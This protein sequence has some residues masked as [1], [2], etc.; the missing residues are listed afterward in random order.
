[1]TLWNRC[2]NTNATTLIVR[3]TYHQS[4]ERHPPGHA[5]I[6]FSCVEKAFVRRPHGGPST[7][8]GLPNS[9]TAA[10]SILFQVELPLIR[11]KRGAKK[12]D[13]RE[14]QT[15]Q[16][17]WSHYSRVFIARNQNLKYYLQHIKQVYVC[18]SL[19]NTQQKWTEY[20][21]PCQKNASTRPSMSR[22]YSAH[23]VICTCL[24][25]HNNVKKTFNLVCSFIPQNKSRQRHYILLFFP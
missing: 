10:F 23:K 22:L 8:A 16:N 7:L 4:S 17:K 19:M 24:S 21:Q 15:N 6:S 20:W 1:M 18:M 9:L 25:V 14:Q 2:R 11:S 3:L 12:N 13:G 5:V